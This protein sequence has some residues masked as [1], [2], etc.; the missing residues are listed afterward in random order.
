MPRRREPS[1][2]TIASLGLS[3]CL[4]VLVSRY[5]IP[6][7]ARWS[8]SESCDRLAIAFEAYGLALCERD[9]KRLAELFRELEVFPG[10]VRRTGRGR[11]REDPLKS[12]E[13]DRSIR[14]R[15]KRL[16]EQLAKLEAE[17]GH[18]REIRELKGQIAVWERTV[19]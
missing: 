4:H 18:G 13:R 15:T 8:V 16:K 5:V 9:P 19:W 11:N 6:A 12:L 17:G 3:E 2:L 1:A 7:S 10:E 14:R